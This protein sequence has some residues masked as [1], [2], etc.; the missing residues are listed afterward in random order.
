MS[1]FLFRFWPVLVPLFIYLLWLWQK[2]RRA[3]KAGEKKPG[4][5]D[6]PWYIAVLASLATG[7]VMFLFLGLSSPPQKGEYIPPHLEDG[8]LVDGKIN[9]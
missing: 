6:G 4:F 3:G 5:R 8:K 1:L 9:P 7:L 2:R